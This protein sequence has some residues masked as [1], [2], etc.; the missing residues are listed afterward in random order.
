MGSNDKLKTTVAFAL[1]TQVSTDNTRHVFAFVRAYKFKKLVS[2]FKVYVADGDSPL[3]LTKSQLTKSTIIDHP[4]SIRLNQLLA[5]I[6]ETIR[7]TVDE[8]LKNAHTLEPDIV[9]TAVK[10]Y[11]KRF[12]SDYLAFL[13]REIVTI[14]NGN[15]TRFDSL[16]VD[17]DVLTKIKN[18]PPLDETGQPVTGD[19]MED[20]LNTEQVEYQKTIDAQKIKK[21]KTEE[22]YRLGLWNKANIFEMFASIYFDQSCPATYQKIVLRLLEYREHKKPKEDVKHLNTQWLVDF[23]NFLNE[24]GFYVI[25]TSNLD[26]LRYD[27]K[28]FF[29]DKKEENPK[30]RK[31]YE[32]KSL[33][34][35]IGI[36]KTLIAGKDK[37]TFYKKG[38]IPKLDLSELNLAA[39]TDKKDVD[40]TRIE[41]NLVKSEV[42][43]IYHFKFTKTSLDEYQE[44]FNTVNKSKNVPITI[45]DLETARQLF[46]LQ[47]FFGGLRGF[48]EL[49]T[50]KLLKHGKEHVVTFYQN[51]VTN[52]VTN[53]LNAYTEAILKP[54]NYKIP[55]LTRYNAQETKKQVTNINL[56]ESHYRSL[57]KTI[58]HIVNLD[59]DVLTD[60][61]KFLHQPIKEIFNPYFSRK[62][63]GT[64]CFSDLGLNDSEISL[65]TGHKDRNKTE[66][67][68]SYIQKDTIKDKKK[69]LE[70]LKIGKAPK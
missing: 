37:F 16:Q 48:I 34:K 53:P 33:N 43:E 65:F 3:L 41:H 58:G 57:L 10:S 4:N 54:L 9:R 49:S 40:G 15:I 1:K 60:K 66:L 51:K 61:V 18:N 68:S 12:N 36:V 28:I 35:M 47:I 19:D 70:K 32:P 62:T 24:T 13:K 27:R 44:I 39:I 22:I 69:L 55:V 20:V 23:F 21:M 67:S 42:D 2:E 17:K 7:A 6:T 5:G 30:E 8:L 52:T 14:T 31:P 56:L 11:T 26:P 59:R 45:E 25:N 50:A 38:Y 29:Q 63:F 64:I 46:I